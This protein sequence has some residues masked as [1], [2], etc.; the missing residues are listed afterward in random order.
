MPGFPGTY[1][2][3]AEFQRLIDQTRHVVDRL[4]AEGMPHETVG[5]GRGS[6][7]R[8]PKE[9]AMAWLVDHRAPPTA[10]GGLDEAELRRAAAEAEIAEMKA[11]RMRGDL[12]SVEA[13]VPIID[14]AVSAARARLL[15]V[16]SKLASVLCPEDPGKARALLD[17]AMLEVLAE[18]ET[19][20]EPSSVSDAPTPH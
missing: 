7:I 5:S 20:L 15:A 13:M 10:A 2:T 17:R 9:A 19:M 1:L 4:L 8:I 11:A 14:R 16:P 12:I 3:R 18:L 6:T